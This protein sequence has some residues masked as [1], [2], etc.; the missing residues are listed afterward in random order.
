[1]RAIRLVSDF[2]VHNNNSW[3][4]RQRSVLFGRWWRIWS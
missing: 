3:V 1:M 4:L 2:R